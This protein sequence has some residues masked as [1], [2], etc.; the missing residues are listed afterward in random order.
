[1][2][3]WGEIERDDIGSPPKLNHLLITFAVHNQS[4]AYYTL[5]V[6]KYYDGSVHESSETIYFRFWFFYII[7]KFL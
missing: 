1:M 3:N 6:A 5:I 4:P 2:K 7:R